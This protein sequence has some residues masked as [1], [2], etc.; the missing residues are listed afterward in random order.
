M[1][2]KNLIVR[3]HHLA[4]LASTMVVPDGDYSVFAELLQGLGIIGMFGDIVNISLDT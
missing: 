4:H 2:T 3:A 1:D